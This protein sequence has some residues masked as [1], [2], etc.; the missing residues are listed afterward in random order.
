[1]TPKKNI[2]RKPAY[3]LPDG[4]PIPSQGKE[5]TPKESRFIYWYTNPYGEAFLNSGRAAVRAGYKAGNAVI[6]GY[7]LRQKQRIAQRIE[8]ILCPVKLD[9][10]DTLYQMANLCAIRMFFDIKDFYRLCKRTVKKK[11]KEIEVD[12]FEII[13]LDELSDTQRMCIDAITVK[14]FYGKD[15]WWYKLPD[16]DKAMDSFF[17]CYKIIMSL[18]SG[19]DAAYKETAEILRGENPAAYKLITDKL[20]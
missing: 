17:K 15:E 12:A 1:M 4:S 20:E 10:H 13:P 2:V 5:F 9:L 3:T 11:G 7:Q 6:Q 16:R 19:K 14:T 8:D 18:E